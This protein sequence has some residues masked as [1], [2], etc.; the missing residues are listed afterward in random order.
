MFRLSLNYLKSSNRRGVGIV[1]KRDDGAAS[2]AD[3]CSL[4]F[5][6]DCRF[7][8]WM[9]SVN[10]GWT[11]LSGSNAVLRH[12]TDTK[13]STYRHQADILRTATNHW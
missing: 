13:S 7:D 9:M 3:N 8:V 5:N 12:S 4:A 2:K 6:L 10:S 1:G 11:L